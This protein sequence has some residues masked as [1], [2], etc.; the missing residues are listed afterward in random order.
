MKQYNYFNNNIIYIKYI[1][2]TYNKY[3]VKRTLISLLLLHCLH[4]NSLN[5][6]CHLLYSASTYITYF[7]KNNIRSLDR[8]KHD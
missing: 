1:Y 7:V 4:K 6:F 5:N 8:S 2:Y 3:F